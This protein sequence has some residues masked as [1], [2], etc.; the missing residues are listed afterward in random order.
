M[1]IYTCITFNINVSF[2]VK[3]EGCSHSDGSWCFG[4]STGNIIIENV[5][6]S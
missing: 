3:E 1:K 2:R 6:M 5:W 4:R